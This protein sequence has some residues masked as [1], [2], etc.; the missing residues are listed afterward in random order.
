MASSVTSILTRDTASDILFQ[1]LRAMAGT[2]SAFEIMRS[3]NSV[4]NMRH[5]RIPNRS[6]KL[7][8]FDSSLESRIAKYIRY[9]ISAVVDLFIHC[10]FA[11]LNRSYI[12][13]EVRKIV[14]GDD[15]GHERLSASLLR[16]AL[17]VCV[18]A[19][20]IRTAAGRKLA[21]DTKWNSAREG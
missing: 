2:H 1:A 11:P 12:E 18:R 3:I 6:N 17:E 4:I 21:I 20:L 5:P 7:T 16:Q 14:L 13:Q 19:K 9:Y 10:E 8:K 15:D